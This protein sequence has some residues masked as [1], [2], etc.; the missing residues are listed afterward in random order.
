M[1]VWPPPQSVPQEDVDDE[2]L[3]RQCRDFF[4]QEIVLSPQTGEDV[5]LPGLANES[6]HVFVPFCRRGR[7]GNTLKEDN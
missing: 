7:T 2:D 4:S 1:A 3:P 5:F 6:V